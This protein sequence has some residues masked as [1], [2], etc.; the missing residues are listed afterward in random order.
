MCRTVKPAGVLPAKAE[1]IK[2]IEAGHAGRDAELTARDS[3][4]I[5]ACPA[6]EEKTVSA[7]ERVEESVNCC[8]SESSALGVKKVVNHKNFSETSPGGGND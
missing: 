4:E 8:T 3:A 5:L 2:P 1:V 6:K 7:K